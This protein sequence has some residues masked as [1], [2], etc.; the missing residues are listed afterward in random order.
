M[1][2]EPN[3]A[4]RNQNFSCNF[5][6]KLGTSNIQGQGIANEKKLRKI[7]RKFENSKLDI[8]LLQETR[9]T[10]DG[11]EMKKSLEK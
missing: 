5:N 3:G 7:S 9:S 4:E 10:G 8:L 6:L 11:K 2:D 1:N